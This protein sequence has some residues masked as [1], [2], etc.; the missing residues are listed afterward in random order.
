MKHDSPYLLTFSILISSLFFTLLGLYWNQTH[1]HNEEPITPGHPTLVTAM[2]GIHDGLL[3]EL[4]R[5]VELW[6]ADNAGASD[7]ETSTSDTVPHVSHDYYEA[8]LQKRGQDINEAINRYNQA[9]VQQAAAQQLTF[10]TA[11]E[12]YFS[13]A[14][15]IGDSRTVGISEYSGIKNAVF[16][17]RTSMTIFDYDK[18]KITYD[19]QKASVKDVLSAHQFG[20]IYLMVGINDC[21]SSSEQAFF[22]RYR[23]VLE[24]IRRLQPDALI[25]LE[26]NLLV[27]SE[28]SATE[29]NITNENIQKRNRLIA[30]LADQKDVFYID[31]ND[32]TL[33]KD[34]ALISDYTWD[35]VHIKAQYYSV[36]KE[37]LLEHAIIKERLS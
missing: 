20:K 21:G 26:G 24:D 10:T 4:V 18:P 16:L 36:W 30:S 37:F 28:K 5:Q 22:K 13:D 27:T 23:E 8:I 11:T 19:N 14:V 12:D 35:Q 29:K 31:I 25:F 32:S 34:G 7:V 3:S 17:C 9:K 2:Q 6:M 15:F 1:Y 33:C